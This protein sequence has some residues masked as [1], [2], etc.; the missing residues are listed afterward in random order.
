MISKV[1]N[2]QVK[3]A[4]ETVEGRLPESTSTSFKQF[5]T[6]LGNSE[7]SASKTVESAKERLNSMGQSDASITVD[8]MHKKML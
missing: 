3:K 7:S 6:D 1:E 8:L 2:D 5:R 4:M